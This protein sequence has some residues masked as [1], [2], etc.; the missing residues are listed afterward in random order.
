MKT[1]STEKFD[2]VKMA[3]SPFTGLY[4]VKVIMFGLGLC[5]I[6]FVGYGVYKAYFRTPDPTTDQNADLI[7]NHYP[8]PRATFGCATVKTY[9]N[10]PTN[11]TK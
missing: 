5:M 9:E 4:W 10:F 3:T 2:I 6:G 7:V 1:Q 11:R 8:E